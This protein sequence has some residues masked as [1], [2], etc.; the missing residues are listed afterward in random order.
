MFIYDGAVKSCF[1]VFFMEGSIVD[2]WLSETL[3]QKASPLIS[4]FSSSRIPIPR[5][6]KYAES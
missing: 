1:T 5:L 3:P 4:V 2:A 6:F